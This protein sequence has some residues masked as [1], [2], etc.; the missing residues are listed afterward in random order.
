MEGSMDELSLEQRDEFVV[1]IATQLVAAGK[2]LNAYAGAV[3]LRLLAQSR[4]KTAP[5]PNTK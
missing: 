3:L 4:A 2:E 1:H 5:Q